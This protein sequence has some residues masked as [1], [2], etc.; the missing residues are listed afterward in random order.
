MKTKYK[1]LLAGYAYKI[2]KIFNYCL[3]RRDIVEVSRYDIRY[4]LDLREGIDLAI[5]LFGRFEPKT[6][7][8]YSK[9]IKPGYTVL[10]IGANIGAHTLNMANL[11][12]P[13][14][15]VIA[16]EPT[17]FAY[18]KLLENIKLNQFL[19]SCIKPYQV[20]LVRDDGIVPDEF[21]FSSWPVGAKSGEEAYMHPVHCGMYKSTKNA[22]A[23]RL[24]TFL[25]ERGISRV[26]F[27]KLDVDGYECDVLAGAKAT[28]ATCK[29]ILILELA[30]SILESHGESLTALIDSLRSMGYELYHEGTLASL[31]SELELLK[32]LI[33]DGASINV[34]AKPSRARD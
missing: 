26:D 8:T 5:F 29:P 27:I 20:M 23:Y 12:G 19:S 6:V 17:E 2:I 3:G 4:R 34:V 1:I 25:N 15:R 31:P 21:I 24:D 10:D 33:G 28:I 22:T 7:R 13:N 16:F 14:G 30:P 11:V 18:S 9:L 32:A